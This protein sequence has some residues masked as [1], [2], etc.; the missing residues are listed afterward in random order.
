MIV[1]AI[2]VALYTLFMLSILMTFALNTYAGD[3]YDDCPQTV[4]NQNQTQ[5]QTQNTIIYKDDDDHGKYVLAGVAITA[6]IWC[7]VKKCWKKD[8]EPY[9]K[10]D[11]KIT[12]DNLSDKKDGINLNI[13]Q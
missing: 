6:G 7:V 2:V 9:Q 4:P 13:Y 3:R 11:G 1:R 10:F 5:I 12:P 8:P